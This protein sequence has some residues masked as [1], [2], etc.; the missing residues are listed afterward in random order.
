MCTHPSEY[1]NILPFFDHAHQCNPG[2]TLSLLFKTRRVFGISLFGGFDTL[3]TLRSPS[4]FCVASMSDLCFVEE[5]C[6]TKFATA[7]GERA[8]VRVCKMVKEGW[9]PTIKM[10]P[11]W[12]LQKHQRHAEVS[13]VDTHPTAYVLQS[14]AGAIAVIGSLIVRPE[15]CS[16]FWGWNRMML[17]S[18]FPA[19]CTSVPESVPVNVSC[20]TKGYVSVSHPCRST[21]RM[22]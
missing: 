17:P 8:V 5:A 1:C 15:M 21:D 14:H 10:D 9:S 4:T 11:F 12:Y 22:V 7:E 3:Q 18:V 6:Q 2:S 19:A 16:E 13:G 20:L